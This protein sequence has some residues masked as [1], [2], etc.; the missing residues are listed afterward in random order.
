MPP[1]KAPPPPPPAAPTAIKPDGGGV[2]DA[3]ALAERQLERVQLQTLRLDLSRN[4]IQDDEALEN[5]EAVREGRGQDSN[6]I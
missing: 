2:A 6:I 5:L 3:E 4:P 1:P